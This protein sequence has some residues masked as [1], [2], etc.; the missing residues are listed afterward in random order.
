MTDAGQQGRER[1]REAT[2][3]AI[4]DAAEEQFSARGFTDVTVRAIAQRAGVSK[5]AV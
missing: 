4:L 3:A 2:T 5:P 1:G